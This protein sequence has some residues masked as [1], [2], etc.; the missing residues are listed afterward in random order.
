MATATTSLLG[1]DDLYNK[2]VEEVNDTENYVKMS[3]K[4]K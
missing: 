3:K 4:P 1:L 2:F